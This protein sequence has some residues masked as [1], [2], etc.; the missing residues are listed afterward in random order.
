MSSVPTLFL[1]LSAALPPHLLGGARGT[2]SE[3]PRLIVLV[4]VDQLIPEQLERLDPWLDGGLGRVWREGLA[5][6]AARLPYSAT[7]TGPGHAT[8][9]TGCLPA[10]HGI[11]A[12]QYHDRNLGHGVY[13]VGDESARTVTDAGA[14]GSSGVS[15]ANLLRPTLGER[16]V[17]ASPAS[18]VVS[19]AGKDRSAVLLGGARATDVLWW[20]RFGAGF[21][22]TDA[23][24]GQVPPYASAWNAHWL[25]E[26]RGWTWEAAFPGDPSGVGTEPDDRPGEKSLL[27]RTTFPYTLPSPDGGAER[28]V[29]ELASALMT[30]PLIDRFTLEVAR[31]AVDAL[32]LGRGEA[33][34]FLAVGLSGCDFAGHAFGPYSCEVTDLLLR[35]DDEL[36][37]LLAHLDQTVGAG[38]WVL[39]LTADHGVLELPESLRAQGIGARR[40]IGADVAAL[41]SRV[42]RALA[43]RYPESPIKF[44][45]DGDGFTLD[46]AALASAGLEREAVRATIAGAAA[47]ADWVAAAYTLEDLSGDTSADPWLAL[48]RAAF[49]PQRCADVVLRREPWTLMGMSVGTSHGSVYPYDRRVPLAFL[50]LGGAPRRSYERATPLDVVPTL[51]E[52]CGIPAAD[53]PLPGRSWVE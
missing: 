9:A 25:E 30:T 5:F 7:E 20:D 24:D 18:R 6:P 16:L 26:A 34:D 8:L 48:H 32:G 19:V 39:A 28:A 42:E 22:T 33:T 36:G 3:P 46:E 17:A 40:L 47:G 38:R 27:G 45:F 53:P 1:L 12:N 13:C 35:A 52:R 37:S 14:R 49:H 31:A 29:G 2:V 21:V 23:V 51:L 43:E 15:A 44:V 11:V 4:S 41:R 10:Q 50:G